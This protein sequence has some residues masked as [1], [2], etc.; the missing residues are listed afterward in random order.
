MRNPKYSEIVEREFRLAAEVPDSHP[1]SVVFNDD[2]ETI[3]VT[4]PDAE[5]VME[6]G[7]D[8]DYFWF[9]KT[10]PGG[11]RVIRFDYP[12]DWI[13]LEENGPWEV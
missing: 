4:T 3:T 8:D 5:W 7:S 11:G 2:E 12:D 13:E 6:I 1:V 9:S 10:G